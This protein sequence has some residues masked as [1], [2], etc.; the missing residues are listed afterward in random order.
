M[1][2]LQWCNPLDVGTAQLRTGEAADDASVC[3]AGVVV[4]VPG[5]RVALRVAAVLHGQAIVPVLADLPLAGRARLYVP[6]V[7]LVPGVGV[8]PAPPFAHLSL[9]SV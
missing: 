8:P 7:V 5:V 6:G 3:A 4:C 2:A 9:E 1:A